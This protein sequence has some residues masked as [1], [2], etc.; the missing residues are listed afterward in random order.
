MAEYYNNACKLN[1]KNGRFVFMSAASQVAPLLKTYIEMKEQAELFLLSSCPE[2]IP[3]I[4]KPGL[5]WHE[6]ERSWSVPFKIASDIGYEINK[7]V[8]SQ[9]PGN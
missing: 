7:K 6:Q 1:Q 9:L 4:L 2:L 8:I 5:V 3:V